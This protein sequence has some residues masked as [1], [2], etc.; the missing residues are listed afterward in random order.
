MNV[1]DGPT[2]SAM[3]FLKT[4]NDNGCHQALHSWTEGVVGIPEGLCDRPEGRSTEVSGRCWQ[5]C[6]PAHWLD[7]PY[8]WAYL[9]HF[10]RPVIDLPQ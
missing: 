1:G 5:L 6:L 3:P 10:G 2:K 7:A 9:Q 4:S 8:L